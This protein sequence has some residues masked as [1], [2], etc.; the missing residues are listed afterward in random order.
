MISVLLTAGPAAAVHRP[1]LWSPGPLPAQTSV[2]VHK[3]TPTPGP[4]SQ[5]AALRAALAAKQ[6]KDTGPSAVHWPGAAAADLHLAGTPHTPYLATRSATTGPLSAPALA[7]AAPAHT[8]AVPLTVAPAGQLTGNLLPPGK[9]T[10]AARAADQA[11]ATPQ[12]VHVAV[13]SRSASHASGIDGLLVSLSRTDASRAPERVSVALDYSGIQD[14]YG[15]GYAD[16]LHLTAYPSCLLTT[17]AKAACRVGTPVA[18][19]ANDLAHHRLVADLT[20]PA[21]TAPLTLPDAATPGTRTT[22]A[23]NNVVVLTSTADASGTS[24]DYKAST[25]A[26]SSKWD[27]SGAT[28]AF[29]YTYPITVPPAPG[30][31]APELALSYNSQAADGR[32][33]QTN[34][35]GSWAG[36]SWTLWPGQIT[37][38]YRTCA[39]DGEAS[40]NQEQ[41]WAGDNATISL[42]GETHDLVPAGDNKW[43]FADDDGS[44]VQ[45]LS[46]ASNGLNN[47][48]YW[49]LTDRA[50]NT[51]VFGADHLPTG[52]GGNGKDT[53]TASAWGAPVYGNNSG[54]PCNAST[55]DASWCTQGWQWNLDFSVDAHGN[56]TVYHYATETNYYGRGSTHTPTAYTRGGALTSITY[57]QKATDYLAGTS[58]PDKVTFT[59]AAEGRCDPAGFTCSGATLSSSNASHWPDVPYDQNCGS[60]SCSHYAPSFWTNDRLTTIATSVWDTSLSTPGYRT[61]DSY[62]LKNQDF[63]NPADGTTGVNNSVSPKAMWLDSIQH[64]GAD[65]GA[66]GAAVLE[67]PVTFKGAFYPNRVPGLS[68]P[69]VTPLSRQRLT[70]I[71]NESGAVTAVTY[72]NDTCSRTSP[73][74]EDKDATTCYPVRWTPPGYSDPILDWFNKYL[75]GEVDVSDN[76]TTNSPPQVSKYDYSA[77]TAAWHHDDDEITAA[78]YRTWDQWRGYSQVTTRT[79]AGTDPVTKS[80]TW[81]LQGMDGDLNADGSHKSASVT[82]A[83]GAAITDKDPWADTAYQ[84]TTYEHDGGYARQRTITIPWLSSAT[85][86]HARG[87]NLPDQVAYHTGTAAEYKMGWITGSTWRTSAVLTTN[88]DATGLPTAV[89]DRGEVDAND[90]PV[91]NSTPEK[92]TRTTYAGNSAGT[93]AGLPAEVVAV[94]GDCTTKADAAHTLTDTKTFYDGSTTLGTVPDNGAGDATSTMSLKDWNGAGGTAEWTTSAKTSYDSYGRPTSATDAMGRTTQTTYLPTGT[95]YLPISIQTT[96]PKGWNATDTLDVARG[97]TTK[98]VDVNGTPS[99]ATYDGL[100]RLTAD[101]LPGHPQSTYSAAPS[102]RYTYSVS[103]TGPSWVETETLRDDFTYRPDYTIYDSFLQQRQE[104][105]IP[106]DGSTAA[107][108]ISDTMYDSH[109]Q[110][111]MSDQ[112][113]FSQGTAPSP[114]FVLPVDAAIP[115][116][117]FT[118]YD[119]MGRT[120]SSTF[121]TGDGTNQTTQ[122]AT[123]TAYP[124]TAE[125]DVTPPAGGTPTATLT[126][127]RGNTVELRQ[128]H[129]AAPTGAY[130]STTYAYDALGRQAK[131]TDSSGNTWTTSYDALGDK[132]K[133]TDPDTGTTLTAYDDDKEPTKTTD[134]RHAPSGGI[135]TTYD[136][137]GRPTDTTATSA[138]GITTTKLTH[139]DYDPTGALGQ[140]AATTSYDT[141]GRAWKNTITGYTPDYLTTGNTLTVPAGAAGNSSDLTYTTG[142][143][144]RTVTR[145]PDQTTLPAIGPM[146]A[147]TVGYQYNEDGLPVVMGGKDAYVAWL[148]YTH[149]GQPLRAS[150]GVDPTTIAETYTYEPYTQ[151]LMGTQL[152]MQTGTTTVEDTSYTYDQAGDITSTTDI[153]DGG[154]SAKTDTQ[155]YTYDYLGRL[156]Q[157][158]TDTGGTTTA[159]DPSIKALG[160]CTHTTPQA[161]NLGGPSPYWQSYTYDATGNRTSETDHSPTGDTSQDATTTETYPAAGAPQPHAVTSTSTGGN[162]GGA[163]TF[164]YDATGNTT[165]ITQAAGT[166]LLASGATIAS[167]HSVTSNTARLSMQADGNL[168]LYSLQ[169]GQ[170]IWSSNTAG[171]PGASAAMQTDGNFTVKDTDGTIL[172]ST[173]TSSPGAIAKVQDDH[174]FTL[175]DTTGNSLWSSGTYSASSASNDAVFTYDDLG[176]LATLT[177]GSTK[178]TYTYDAAGDLIARNRAGAT[179]LYLGTDELVLGSTGLAHSDTRYYSL[180][181]A[182]T[183]IRTATTSTSSSLSFEYTDP[184]GT[185]TTD[186]SADNKT[187]QRRMYTPFGTDR[188]PG[189]NPTTWPGSKGYVGG[190]ADTITGLTNLGARE[191]SPALGRF[192]TTDPVQALSDPQQWNGYAYADDDPVNESDPSGLCPRDLCDGYGQNPLSAEG[193]KNAPRGTVYGHPSDHHGSADNSPSCTSSIPGCP[194]YE[195]PQ[196]KMLKVAKR[197]YVDSGWGKA[198]QFARAYQDYT[199]QWCSSDYGKASC[200]YTSAQG[201]DDY[202]RLYTIMMACSEIGG[203]PKSV[204]AFTSLTTAGIREGLAV[205][206][207]DGIRSDGEEG[208]FGCSFA[209]TTPVLMADG[210]KKPIGKIKPGDKVEAADPDTGKD[211]GGRAVEHVW[212]NHDH[213][214]LNLTLKTGQGH[215]ATLKTTANHP[216]YDQTAHTWIAAGKLTPGHH[217][218]TTAGHAASVLA[219]TSTRGTA[220]RD[221]LTVQQLHTYYVVAGGTPILVHNSNGS[222][223]LWPNLEKDDPIHPMTPTPIGD[224]K[225]ATGRFI[226]VLMENGDLRVTRLGGQYGHID[227][228]QGD[229]VAAAGEFKLYN[230]RLKEMDNRSGHYQPSGPDPRMAAEEAFSQAGFDVGPNTYRERW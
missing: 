183:A 146:P 214:L 91:G 154:G 74:S 63:P 216:F 138:D 96:N 133:T 202:Q 220:D 178:T 100:G 30:G 205:G 167:G 229:D 29:T 56:L 5:P 84:T 165:E 40:A 124:S 46:G 4:R 39:D 106:P 111:V 8:A 86:T 20:L 144:Y 70:S 225:N 137:L 6:P 87:G 18:A 181:G 57:G 218:A 27:T 41:C 162:T 52:L 108:L 201:P 9:S 49:Q 119:G 37:R 206:G 101:W 158:W 194:G 190:T 88:D 169:S 215:I 48:T 85:A 53:S 51:F 180:P 222:C 38:S 174:N 81:Y 28:G 151:R 26:S 136:T 207:K 82:P 161:S 116:E 230:G 224:L 123:T 187:V 227:L 109:G 184:H 60:S 21:T 200:P 126:D 179:T 125:T 104:Q 35:Q 103:N 147:E 25:L 157:A 14:A 223:R 16:R 188:S 17:P 11:A 203:C 212:I 75:V 58:A 208:G 43:K 199:H 77:G 129:G 120:T 195:P 168:V 139:T 149:L 128:F 189:G 68:E 156:T 141:A 24:G 12:A 219:V 112:P 76:T 211:T 127:A 159:P 115:G 142:N 221:N 176:R 102:S 64:T 78:K 79:G 23:N 134:A 182:P 121:K 2:A 65:T 130:D 33:S 3:A 204:F 34:N 92:C 62:A 191:Y 83:H 118:T 175:Y 98:S 99:T 228:A 209:P 36:D 193:R 19:S 163:Q 32:T 153:Q 160:S 15:G 122:W 192:L 7:A 94:S 110:T 80:I 185:G 44:V 150:M 170:A 93:I 196:P 135:T 105:S 143:T 177:Q 89:D 31:S 1:K 171:H 61:V 114:D 55:L 155:C 213:D 198:A 164:N 72:Q 186:I 47:G 226:Y 166:K 42:N 66:G 113:Y 148:D 13:A 45:E 172:W 71:T 173:G 97:L 69:A 10:N 197:V 131:V 95:K 54:E 132:V 117:T 107:R 67:N 210:K 73:P 140:V 217:L 152:Q 90:T 59:R 22:A 50:G 145:Q